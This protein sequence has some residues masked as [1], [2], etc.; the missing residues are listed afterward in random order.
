MFPLKLTLTISSNA[1]LARLTAFLDGNTAAAVASAPKLGV[2]A[3]E[4]TAVLLANEKALADTAEAPGKPS[5]AKTA[6]SP[7]TAEAAHSTSAQPGA[8]PAT[9]TEATPQAAAAPSASPLVY[10][11]LQKVVLQLHSMDPAAPVP[12]AK[13]LGFDSF[14]PLKEAANADKIPAAHAAVVAKINELKAA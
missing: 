7:R 10:A 2:S 14:K 13:S 5:A 4:K 12:I 3:D 9:S 1:E 6:R 8:A 11:D